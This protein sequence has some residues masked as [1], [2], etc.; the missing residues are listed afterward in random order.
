LAA[1]AGL[2]QWTDYML[3]DTVMVDLG[4]RKPAV[5]RSRREDIPP[6]VAEALG[7]KKEEEP[8]GN[9]QGHAVHYLAAAEEGDQSRVVHGS[10][11]SSHHRVPAPPLDC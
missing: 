9:N 8:V 6:D 11:Q 10:A 7:V 4:G 2:H 1:A 5:S 3:C